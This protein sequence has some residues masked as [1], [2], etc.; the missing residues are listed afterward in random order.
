MS[1]RGDTLSIVLDYQFNGKDIEE[2]Q[3]DEMEFQ[4]GPQSNTNS[5]KFLLSQDEIYWDD[6]E[7]CYCV[8]LSQADT[9]ALPRRFKY[10]L[11]VLKDGE[12]VSSDISHA[13]VG[14]VLSSNVLG[15]NI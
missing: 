14:E 8:D 15:G 6:D 7:E 4:I 1:N 10:Q 13:T 2:G 11:R 12:V 5:R 9:F 3:F